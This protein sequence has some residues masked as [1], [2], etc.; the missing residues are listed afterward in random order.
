M[1]LFGPEQLAPSG[2]GLAQT[3][4][5]ASSVGKAQMRLTSQSTYALQGSPACFTGAQIDSIHEYP[6]GHPALPP[7]LLWSHVSPGDSIVGS[8]SGGEV[9]TSQVTVQL[10]TRRLQY[11]PGTHSS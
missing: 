11:A 10:G 3:P 6:E 5:E 9:S 2:S 4:S 1:Q 8:S 7:N